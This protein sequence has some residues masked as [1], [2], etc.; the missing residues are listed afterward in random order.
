MGNYKNTIRVTLTIVMLLGLSSCANTTVKNG[1]S[2]GVSS[3]S[4]T[5]KMYPFK[6]AILKYKQKNQT[7]IWDDWGVKHY[8]S[9][10]NDRVIMSSNG[11]EYRVSHGTKKITK[12]HNPILIYLLVADKNLA[13]YY[14]ATGAVDALYKTG[15]KAKVAGQT[16]NIW[17][18]ELPYPSKKYCLYNDLILLKKEVKSQGVWRVEKEAYVAKFNSKIDPQLFTKIPNYPIK[19]FTDNETSEEIQQKMRKSPQEY[20]SALNMAETIKKRG[21]KHRES[22]QDFLRENKRAIELYRQQK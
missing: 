17:V 4:Q 5:F 2:N 6:S 21:I 10:A 1:T 19:D 9:K 8:E 15:K 11:L 16:C 7:L 12:S 13:P 3:S 14:V 22:I 20:K 18:N